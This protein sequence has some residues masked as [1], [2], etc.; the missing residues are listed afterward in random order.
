MFDNSTE[1][2]ITLRLVNWIGLETAV[3]QRLVIDTTPPDTGWYLVYV[4]LLLHM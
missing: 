1:A 3:F 2:V 4:A